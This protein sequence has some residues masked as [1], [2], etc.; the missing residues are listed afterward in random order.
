M[1]VNIDHSE[2]QTGLLKKTTYHDISC[3]ITFSD[4]EK[5]IIKQRELGDLIVMERDLPADRNPAK[6]EN[7]EYIFNLLLKDLTK[8]VADVYT[9]ATPLDAKNYDADLKEQLKLL[10]QYIDGNTEIE[11]KSSAFEL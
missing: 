4:E 11:E 10:K 9:V 3:K 6:Y 7:R 5:Q 1:R 8:G 2:R